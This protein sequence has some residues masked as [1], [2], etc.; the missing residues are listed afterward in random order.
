[1]MGRSSIPQDLHASDHL[2]SGPSGFTRVGECPN[3]KYDVKDLLGKIFSDLLI[4]GDKSLCAGDGNAK[5]WS[6]TGFRAI[7]FIPIQVTV[8]VTVGLD[9]TVGSGLAS[10][11][12][13]IQMS[14]QSGSSGNDFGHDKVGGPKMFENTTGVIGFIHY[15][16]AMGF[17][18]FELVHS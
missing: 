13:R 4:F 7:M 16:I 17:T 14:V 6:T 10:G 18:H 1:M 12:N 8:E 2:R 9:V 3:F 11:G 15:W 5:G